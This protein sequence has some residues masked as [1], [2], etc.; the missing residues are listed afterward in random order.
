[1]A[2]NT[3]IKKYRK[4]L[5]LNIGMVI[6]GAIFIYVIVCV[7]MYFQTSHIVRYE[8]QEGSLATNNTYRGVILREETVIYNP[9]A[10][11]V[12]YYAREGERVAKNALV[13]I[14]D[15][16]G[17]LSENLD[18]AALGENSLSER[19]LSEFR[20]EI[21]NFV[22]SFDSAHYDSTYDVKH[23][24]KNT[25]LKIANVNM[26]NSVSSLNAG[27]GV[28]QYS[29]SPV[30][31]VVSYWTDGYEELKAQEI[32]EAT[33]DTKEGYEKKQMLSNSLMAAGD[34]VYKICTSEDWSLVIPMDDIV[35]AAQLQED[36]VVKVRFLKNQYESWAEVQM[37]TNTD[38][39]T[40]LRLDFNNSMV[41]FINDRFLDVELILEDETGL[42]IPV[43]SIVQKEFYL[44]PEDFVIPGGN[45]GGDSILRQCYLEDGTISSEQL[46]VE[47]YYF[48]SETKEYYLDSSLLDAGTVLYRLDSQET[49]TVSKRATLIGVY[50]MNK[51]YADF[52]QINILYQNDEYAIVKSNTKYG[53]NVYDYIVL[54]AE[55]VIDD[56]LINQ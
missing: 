20:S 46:E 44:I 28:V 23:S 7:I 24:L 16:T 49:Y 39:K 38:G 10:G 6:F 33:F 41:T 1:M 43:S 55:A 3:K 50:N 27:V 54:N 56:Q 26:L 11:Y 19:E 47:V 14:V 17:R 35:R 53:L 34:A 45:S 8:V 4:P 15:E 12:N 9:T 37:L 5:N 32:T 31:G 2:K 42:K 52:K 25:V 21:I 40:Y 36:G 22:H 51:G 48:D 30:T 18:A 13:F 29:Y